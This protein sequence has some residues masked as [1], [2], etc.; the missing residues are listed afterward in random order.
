MPEEQEWIEQPSV[1]VDWNDTQWRRFASGEYK[2]LPKLDTLYGVVYPADHYLHLS[3]TDSEQDY[4]AYTPNAEYGERDRQVRLKFGKYLRKTFPELSDAV[5]QAAVIE[6]RVK[7]ARSIEVL[8]FATDRETINQIFE[9]KMCP[10]DSTSVSCMYGKWDGDIVRPY[11]VYADSPDVA[12]VYLT[13]SAAIVARSVVSTKDKRWVR[14]Y[15]VDGCSTLC[16]LLKDALKAQ[17][18]ERG[19]LDGNRLT[20]CGSLVPYLDGS[21]QRITVHGKYWIVCEDGEYEATNTDG[22]YAEDVER[23]SSCDRPE[24]D[25]ECIYCE[26]CEERYTD[27]CENCS[28]CEACDRCYN[29][30]GC[31]CTRCEACS[32]LIDDCDCERCPDCD[33]LE[34]ACDCADENDAEQSTGVSA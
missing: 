24:D 20:R 11:H 4:V 31:R 19:D 16:T 12:V 3:V 34:D 17:G 23:C 15:A 27:S 33:A 14:L 5:I 21:V 22:T 7:L 26:C 8:C 2:W 9:T 32:Q 25:C 29:H 30:D 13:R 10:C 28:M 1:T 18:Y 6:L